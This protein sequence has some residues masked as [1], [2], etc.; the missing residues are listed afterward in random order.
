MATS[1]TTLRNPLG[2]DVWSD[3]AVT[4]S[5]VQMDNACTVYHMEFDNTA[6]AAVTY[7][8]VYNV[9]SGS[10][11]LG[12]TQPSFIFPCAANTKQYMTLPTAVAFGTAFTYIATS[13]L[14]NATS[15]SAPTTAVGLT[16]SYIP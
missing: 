11:T 9:A 6:N 13:T 1:N 7:Y 14:S 3:T 8:T 16:V 4:N 10:V 5:L 12:T 15:Q 2:T